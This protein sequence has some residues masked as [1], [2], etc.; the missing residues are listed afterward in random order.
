MPGI[1][2]ASIRMRGD[3]CFDRGLI[4]VVT[5]FAG[6]GFSR[7]AGLQG[8]APGVDDVMVFDFAAQD[9]ADWRKW[10]WVGH[11]RGGS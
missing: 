3:V 11:S 6:N 10:G 2:L 5:L 9:D 1:P 8:G 7:V 4:Y